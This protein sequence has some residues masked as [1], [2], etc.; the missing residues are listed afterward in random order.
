M[1]IVDWFSIVGA[2]MSL[3][4]RASLCSL[5]CVLMSAGTTLAQNQFGRPTNI[6]VQLPVVS[7]FNVRTTVS[8]PDGGMMSL[9][10]VSRSASGSRSSGVPGLGGPLFRNRGIGY[11]TGGS[12][13]VVTA[14]IISNREIEEDLLAEGNRRARMRERIDPNGSQAVQAKAD[15]ISR[16]IGRSRK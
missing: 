14:T 3:I 16:N 8:V 15:F 6:A 5:I 7:F 11:S 9:G 4:V 2:E 1:P 10:G 13:A 12:R